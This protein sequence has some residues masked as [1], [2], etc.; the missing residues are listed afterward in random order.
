MPTNCVAVER[1]QVRIL[2][3]APAYNEAGDKQAIEETT[4]HKT[5]DVNEST[6]QSPNVRFHPLF[7]V[8]SNRYT[9]YNVSKR[10][11]T[12]NAIQT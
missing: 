7:F 6:N 5:I 3:K 11:I 2:E 1:D 8:L 10:A 12:R 9:F 4:F